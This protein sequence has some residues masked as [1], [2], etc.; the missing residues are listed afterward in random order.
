MGR[1]NWRSFFRASACVLVILAA[2]LLA[3]P[4]CRSDAPS[5]TREPTPTE[6]VQPTGTTPVPSEGEPTGNPAMENRDY[7]V[8]PTGNNDGPGTRDQPLRTISRAADLA[9]PGD[10]VVIRDG[11]Y[12]EVVSLVQSGTAEHPIVFQAENRHG[13][14]LTGESNHFR[15]FSPG[16]GKHIVLRGFWFRNCPLHPSGMY[17][18]QVVMPNTG[19]R[20]ED[21]R[22]TRCGV[23]IG[24]STGS[25][26]TSNITVL[27]CV[28]EDMAV[29][30]SWAWAGPGQRMEGHRIQD[31]I[32]RRCN[33][34]NLDP[35]FG[36]MGMKYG[37]TRN[38][39]ADG[40]I[41]YDNNGIGFWLDWNNE[42][43]L[44]QNCTF[45]GNHAGMAYANFTDNQLRNQK[46]AGV[47][48]ASEGNPSGRFL[49]NTC[50]SNLWSGVSL[51]ESGYDGGI[52]VE[53][54]LFVDNSIHVE[55]RAMDRRS[56]ED[57]MVGLSDVTLRDN[58]FLD[59]R[60]VC[61]YTGGLVDTISD[62]PTPGDA[63]FVIDRNRYF[64]A[65]PTDR[66]FFGKWLNILTRSF[67]EMQSKLGV[68][69]AG[70]VEPLTFDATRIPVFETT[71]EDVGTS[72]MTQV[73]SALAEETTIDRAILG[74]AEGDTATIPVFG[75]KAIRQEGDRWMTEVYDLQARYVTLVLTESQARRLEEEIQ[76]FASIAPVDIGIRLVT[77]EPYRIE[78]TLSD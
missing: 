19:W 9:R 30:A 56:D 53:G 32:L 51:W 63:G 65:S 50:Y 21:C 59:W 49:G 77:V 5:P 29:T 22:F 31:T 4:S 18:A 64:L 8:D 67:G 55:F 48:F 45:F 20:V 71:L 61:W 2:L 35:G 11:V 15:P 74:L 13:A 60:D 40:V 69:A 39:V 24:Y 34:L 23:G 38:L 72:R 75:R 12:D 57:P 47:G 58:R 33:T 16:Y 44:V 46:W 62:L 14:V 28:F 76:P 43:F 3:T 1:P 52:L 27:R 36:A 10:R 54:N 78:A 6:F 41:S 73:P 37:Y 42:N 7:W 70:S 25:I 26:D 68:E 66:D 17:G